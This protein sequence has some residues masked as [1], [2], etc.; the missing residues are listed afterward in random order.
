[1]LHFLGVAVSVAA[2]GYLTWSAIT[3]GAVA[4]QGRTIAWAFTVASGMGATV[5]LVLTL[6]LALRILV[7]LGVISRVPGRRARR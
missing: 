3:F 7:K 6:V 4:R 1:V 2:W 5:C